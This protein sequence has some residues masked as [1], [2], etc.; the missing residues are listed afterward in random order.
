VSNNY[1]WNLNRFLLS[2]TKYNLFNK[3]LLKHTLKYNK[4]KSILK[5]NRNILQIS[6]ISIKKKYNLKNYIW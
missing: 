2:K 6:L 1:K 5:N 3:A 4:Y